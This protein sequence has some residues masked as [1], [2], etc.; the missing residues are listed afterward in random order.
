MAPH[1]VLD[2]LATYV[3]RLMTS[4]A[5]AR[6]AVLKTAKRPPRLKVKKRLEPLKHLKQME[7]VSS[8][9]WVGLALIPE[10]A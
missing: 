10:Q 2:S 4:R 8:K 3:N 1:A 5:L 9:T 6:E 7:S